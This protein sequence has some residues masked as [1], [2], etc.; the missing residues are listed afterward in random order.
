LGGSNPIKGFNV[1]HCA[2]TEITGSIHVKLHAT[3]FVDLPKKE[4]EL[5]SHG[6]I[7]FYGKLR[8]S[9]LDELYEKIRAVIVPSICPEP[10][11]YVMSEAFLK[12]RLV[13]ASD[14]GGLPELA[15][16][17]KGAF[18][19]E[20][21]NCKKLAD[22]IEYAAGL[23]REVANDFAAQSRE[24][25]LKRFSNEATINS[26]VGICNELMETRI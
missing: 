20:P 18:L 22:E 6:E 10:L 23:S 1:L 12:G 13:I 21:G 16:G 26:F 25:L 11:S 2:L 4:P 5:L 9:S 19:F 17:C 14:I 15:E 3:N 8:Y 7:F 24:T